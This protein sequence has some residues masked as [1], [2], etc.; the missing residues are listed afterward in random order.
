ATV[1]QG[2]DVERC[3]LNVNESQP[4]TLD[5]SSG[6]EQITD[7]ATRAK[8]EVA[9]GAAPLAPVAPVRGDEGWVLELMFGFGR[10]HRE[11]SYERRL[12]DFGFESKG[13]DIDRYSISAGRRLLPY[14]VT[15][16]SFSNLDSASYSRPNIGTAQHFDWNSHAVAAF[17]Q[18]D[19]SA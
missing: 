13:A 7:D 19:V 10:G 3:A 17:V 11:D 2:S 6:C 18:G 4:S 5:L 12:T 1:R 9:A 16:V 15:G 8:G 14:L